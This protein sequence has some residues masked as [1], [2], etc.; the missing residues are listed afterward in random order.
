V[1]VYYK[2]VSNS[3]TSICCGFVIQ[4]VPIVVHDISPDSASRGPAAVA[5][6]LAYKCLVLIFRPHRINEA[7]CCTNGTF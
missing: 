6:L 2:S 3:T 4:L 1:A 7:Y 5:E